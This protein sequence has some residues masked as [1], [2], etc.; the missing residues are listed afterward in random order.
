M[1]N[2]KGTPRCSDRKILIPSKTNYGL[3]KLC[4]KIVNWRKRTARIPG[5]GS[6]Y[7]GRET[8]IMAHFFAQSRGMCEWKNNV[9]PD[10]NKMRTQLCTK[11]WND[12]QITVVKR[13]GDISFQEQEVISGDAEAPPRAWRSLRGLQRRNIRNPQLLSNIFEYILKWICILVK[14]I[15]LPWKRF[16]ESGIRE[17]LDPE[18]REKSCT[19]PFWPGREHRRQI[20]WGLGRDPP[21]PLLHVETDL[22]APACDNTCSFLIFYMNRKEHDWKIN[23]KVQGFSPSITQLGSRFFLRCY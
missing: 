3:P 6:H 4:C 10:P 5:N 14:E 15:A 20:W 22:R 18:E 17:H 13:R 9:D 12:P 8:W 16:S 11:S 2:K 19:Y 23:N 21:V 7:V 1:Q